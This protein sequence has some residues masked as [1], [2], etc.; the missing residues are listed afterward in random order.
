MK[1]IKQ[2]NRWNKWQAASANRRIFSGMLIVAMMTLIVKFI[3]AAKELVIADYFGTGEMVDAFLFA[4]LL[5]SFAINVLSGSF[6]AA[7]M[8]TYIRTREKKGNIAA[9][10][11]FSS[12]ML[13]GLLFL[14]LTA[15]IL[16]FFAPPLLALLGSGFNEQTMVLTQSL[17]YWLL[18]SIVLVGWGHLFSTIINADERFALVALTPAITP[19]CSVIALMTQVQQWGIYA[20]AAGVLF[21]AAIELLILMI[22]AKLKNIHVLPR[23]YGVTE[24]LR[25]VLGQYTPMIAGAFLMSGTVLVDQSMAATLETGSVAILNYANKV[26]A[27]ILGIGSMALGTVVLPYFSGLVSNEDWSGIKH[28]FKVYTRLIII[29]TLP[30]TAVLFFFSEPIIKLL[31]QRGAFT[32]QDTQQVAQVQAYYLLQLPFYMLGM[33]GVRLISALTKNN[34]LMKI[35]FF[36]L[37]INI[38]GNYLLIQ[39]FGVAGIALSTAIVYLFSTM[40]IYAYILNNQFGGGNMN[41]VSS[42]DRALR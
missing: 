38:I 12:I 26:V 41:N 20:L 25:I 30:I 31:F 27:M 5:P 29:I 34:I 36:N 9:G 24:E 7:L 4:Y 8:P 16:A 22:A 6:G 39:Y 19:I 10:K 33:L 2:L 32:A 13:I 42:E 1:L 35:A 3:A 23:W 28:T 14:T 11:L 15:V 21:G 18:P 37:I 40:M 17:L